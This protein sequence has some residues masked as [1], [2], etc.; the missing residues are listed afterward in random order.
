MWK[1]ARKF[2]QSVPNALQPLTD[3]T[4][5]RRCILTGDGGRGEAAKPPIYPIYV[6]VVE[7]FPPNAA[8]WSKLIH[9]RFNGFPVPKPH[10][11]LATSSTAG[12]VRPDGLGTVGRSI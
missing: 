9:S 3:M 12:T 11:N 1:F 5:V 7:S 10:G 8:E 6:R 2:V 4:G